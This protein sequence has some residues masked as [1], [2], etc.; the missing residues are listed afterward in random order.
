MFHS[1]EEQAAFAPVE[2]AYEKFLEVRE[3]CAEEWRNN[4]SEDEDSDG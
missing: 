3:Q 1:L 4:E 2:E